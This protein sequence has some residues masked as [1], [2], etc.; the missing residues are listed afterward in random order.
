VYMQGF[1]LGSGLTY[2]MGITHPQLFAA[3]SPNSGIGPMS[4]EVGAWV[5][6]LK[7]K[8]DARIPMMIVYGD[9]DGGSST[10]AKIPA[11]GVLRGAIDE[12]KTYNRISTPDR[13]VTFNSPNSAPYDILLPGG[14][15]VSDGLGARYPKGRFKIAQY[16]SSDPT[17]LNLFNFVWVTDLPHGGDPR[18]AKLEWDYFKHW[19][20]NPDGTLA[21]SP[22]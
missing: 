1:S 17:P 11:Q 20:R 12:M 8:S 22:R 3:V 2:M 4:P 13:V 18:Q 15:A 14:K 7:A 21:Y 16:S 6:D 5:S 9:V 10:D 19:R